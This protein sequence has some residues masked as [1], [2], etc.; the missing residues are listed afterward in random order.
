MS[1]HRHYSDS[2]Y[3][4]EEQDDG[5]DEPGVG[6][7]G[8]GG[9]GGDGGVAVLADDQ[10]W[11]GVVAT[12]APRLGASKP[13]LSHHHHYGGNREIR[14]NDNDGDNDLDNAYHSDDDCDAESDDDWWWQRWD[15][16]T[17]LSL[18][19]A[20]KPRLSHHH[21]H[22]GGNRE[23]RAN[24]ND[25]DNDLD[26]AYHSDDD[27]DAESDDV[28]DETMRHVSTGWGPPNPGW[29]THEELKKKLIF[30]IVMMIAM[31]TGIVQRWWQWGW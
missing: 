15:D 11:G 6:A 30:M 20:S 21:H 28:S 27:C 5:G 17:R 3:W 31:M 13:R 12:R 2:L 1:S 18:L 10:S 24:D 29:V 16:E 22:C 9:A 26:N 25:G 4:P 8:V 23:L 14:V 7:D 19:G